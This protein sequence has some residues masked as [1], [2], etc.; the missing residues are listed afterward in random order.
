M[1][2]ISRICLSLIIIVAFFSCEQHFFYLK[3]VKAN[4][5]ISKIENHEKNIHHSAIPDFKESFNVHDSSQILSI[6]TFNK[7]SDDFL[8]ATIDTPKPYII[9]KLPVVEDENFNISRQKENN[10]KTDTQK[11][12]EKKFPIKILFGILLIL[13]GVLGIFNFYSYSTTRHTGATI[14]QSCNDGCAALFYG[15]LGVGVSITGLI[16]LIVGL[17]QAL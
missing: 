13:L 11:P 2:K 16:L 4:S 12:K 5:S 17:V 3:K 8:T 9:K 1:N 15:I 6:N 14:D 7:N 10:Q